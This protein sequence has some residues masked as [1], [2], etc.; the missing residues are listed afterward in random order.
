M[1]DSREGRT[2]DP[3]L[4]ELLG[5]AGPEHRNAVI[6]RLLHE[7][8]Y[9]RVDAI[10]VRRLQRSGLPLEH[11][12]DLRGEVLFK[13]VSRLSRLVSPGPE[14]T[15]IESLP[16]YVSVVAFNT[17]DEF[18]RRTYPLRAQLKN[19]IRYALRHDGRF[20][21]WSTATDVLCGYR[22]HEGERGASGRVPAESNGAGDLRASL[23]H[24]FDAANGSLPLDTVVDEIGRL[25][26]PRLQALTAAAG[27]SRHVEAT[28]L[29]QVMVTNHLQHL[30]SEIR[31]LPRSQRVAL[32]LH[33]RDESGQS[34]A[35]LLPLLGIAG[36]REV[37]AALELRW[38]TFARLWRELP[39]DDLR[40]AELLS[41]SRQQVINLRRSARD[42]L[43]RRLR[44]AGLR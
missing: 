43:E 18:M 4:D 25:E 24:L 35:R 26:L 38:E 29:E 5:T 9:A 31:A 13:L 32:L 28:A 22:R 11:H 41:L 40:I 19:R 14:N 30:W 17:F 39:L 2:N 20:A 10:L 16:D 15:P 44:K 37:A 6:D 7:H 34:A 3:L 33:A 1:T 42:R 27:E 23:A 36:V 12:E 8:V 21:L